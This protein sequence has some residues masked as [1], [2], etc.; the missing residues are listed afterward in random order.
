MPEST[1]LYKKCIKNKIRSDAFHFL[2]L[3]EK[4]FSDIPDGNVITK[5]Y[6]QK[7]KLADGSYQIYRYEYECLD[8]NG[9]QKHL[10]VKNKDSESRRLSENIM[11]KRSVENEKKTVRASLIENIKIYYG[12]KEKKAEKH[13]VKI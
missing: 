3:N 2:R 1:I 11:E 13:L 4:N 6:I 5:H 10:S 7:K 8:Y 12:C 9:K